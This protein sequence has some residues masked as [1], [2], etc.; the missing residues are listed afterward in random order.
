MGLFLLAGIFSASRVCHPWTVLRCLIVDDSPQF[1]AAARGLLER[2]GISVVGVASTT[3]EALERVEELR[4]D[5]ALLDINLG[6][7]SGFDLAARLHRETNPAPPRMILISTQDEAD[8][9]D[10][11]AASPVIGFL[12]KATL[13]AAAIH[14]LLASPN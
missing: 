13:S 5:V 11:I 14:E 4:P 2:E 6:S 7:E 8:Y 12:A 3:A 9:A 1:L 10:L